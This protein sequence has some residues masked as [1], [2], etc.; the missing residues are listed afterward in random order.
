MAIV[1]F[2]P[3]RK[4]PQLV[5]NNHNNPE[6]P[7]L[8]WQ[9]DDN[10]FLHKRQVKV[11]TKVMNF[12][13]LDHQSLWEVIEIRTYNMASTGTGRIMSKLVQEVNKLSDDVTVRKM[14]DGE[15][16]RISFATLSYSAIWRL[17][18]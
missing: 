14:N 11:G 5:A 8:R 6:E 9:G 1:H 13:R 15:T 2:S 16:R 3:K 12:G 17:V 10:I 18:S 4:R 7:S